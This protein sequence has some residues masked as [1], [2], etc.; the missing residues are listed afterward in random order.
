M[1]RSVF[2]PFRTAFRAVDPLQGVCSVLLD[3][4]FLFAYGFVTKPVSDKIV[5]HAVIIGDILSRASKELMQTRDASP[6][7]LELLFTNQEARP[8]VLKLVV[9]LVLLLAVVYAVYWFFQGTNW[10]LAR[11]A[12]RGE[13][14]YLGYMGYF[15]R[16]NVPWFLFF[17]FISL[18]QVGVSLYGVVVERVLQSSLGAF[19]PMVLDVVFLVV[20]FAACVSYALPVRGA[21]WSRVKESFRVVFYWRGLAVLAALFAAFWLINWLL[22]WAGTRGF[23]FQAVLGVVVLLPVVYV[24][25][26]V[27]VA[28]VKG[29]EGSA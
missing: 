2:A 12:A 8:F 9:L 27:I 16:V 3:V 21:G 14:E 5:E 25:R 24:S 29:V 4:A 17:G 1:V 20:F 7:L 10:K 13:G 15:A 11:D 18:L 23:A 6:G 19:W 26:L 28:M 22:V